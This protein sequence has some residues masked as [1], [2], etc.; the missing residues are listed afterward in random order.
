[1]AFPNLKGEQD[2]PFI[3]MTGLESDHQTEEGFFMR[4]HNDSPFWQMYFLVPTKEAVHIID[5]QKLEI[6]KTLLCPAKGKPLR[7]W[8]LPKTE[9]M[10]Y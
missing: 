1:M 8:N 6:V 3:D 10:R 5:K 9:S 2:F 7:M 4:S